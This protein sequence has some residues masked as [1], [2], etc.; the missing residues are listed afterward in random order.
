VKIPAS[1]YLEAGF[2]INYFKKIYAKNLQTA[3]RLAFRFKQEFI[4]FIKRTFEVD[5]DQSECVYCG[6]KAT[7]SWVTA[8][9]S[10]MRKIENGE[11]V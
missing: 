5:I 10:C 4:G 6:G 1:R 8:C 2:D 9:E 11:E 3:L 7:Y